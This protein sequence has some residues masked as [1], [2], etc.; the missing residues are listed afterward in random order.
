VL[1]KEHII[2][3]SD[4][5]RRQSTDTVKHRVTWT[6]YNCITKRVFSGW[7]YEAPC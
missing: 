7:T 5:V 1:Y 3:R 2:K 4:S 6:C